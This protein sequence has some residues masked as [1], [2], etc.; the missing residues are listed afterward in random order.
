MVEECK[1]KL[2]DEQVEYA[3]TQADANAI[4]AKDPAKYQEL[5]LKLK[6]LQLALENESKKCND[7]EENTEGMFNKIQ[8]KNDEVKELVKFVQEACAEAGQS[9]EEVASTVGI[10]TQIEVVNRLYSVYIK[11][12]EALGANEKAWDQQMKNYDRER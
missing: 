12:V 10:I 3:K 8:G 9:E 5:S 7:D 11:S 1:T 2:K 6:A 4:S